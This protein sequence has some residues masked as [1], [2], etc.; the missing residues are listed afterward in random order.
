M[1]DL[2][3]VFVAGTLIIL[4]FLAFWILRYCFITIS[5]QDLQELI[6]LNH[7]TS[8][9]L[10][11]PRKQIF[12][13]EFKYKSLQQFEDHTIEQS[14]FKYGQQHLKQMTE[15]Y[16]KIQADEETYDTYVQNYFMIRSRLGRSWKKDYHISYNYYCKLEQKY[17][18]RAIMK[19]GNV[20]FSIRKS[21]TSR[22][23][24]RHY[25]ATELLYAEDFLR[26]LGNV[27]ALQKRRQEA[28]KERAKMSQR[29][30]YQILVRD[31]G[32]CQLC[33]R[34]YEHGVV[35]QV[36][37]I[38][39]VSKGGKTVP[40]NLRVLCSECNLG[41]GALLEPGGAIKSVNYPCHKRN[42]L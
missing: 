6:I 35:L 41:K 24:R 40:S 20:R 26:I 36:D 33:G 16:E 15:I 13:I 8:R 21:Y 25:E 4:L 39:P 28:C 11:Y 14:L 3:M 22:K 17:F 42:L 19:P 31:G 30:R 32:H 23:K 9:K 1:P 29:M 5:S 12:H 7:N 38:I 34:G 18:K 2:S 27:F 10:N 37:H